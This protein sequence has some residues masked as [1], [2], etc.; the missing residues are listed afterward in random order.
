MK[1]MK[2]M[3][4]IWVLLTASC[5]C[6]ATNDLKSLPDMSTAPVATEADAKKTV[7]QSVV[8]DPRDGLSANHLIST[9]LAFALG[10]DVPDFGKKGERVWQVHFTELGGCTVRIAWVNAE[11]RKVMFLMEEKKRTPNKASDAT[12]EPAPGAA[13]SSHQR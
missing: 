7:M 1:M 11:T 5:V 8:A 10:F 6:G 2:N 4:A 13:S 3:M 9:K 12:S